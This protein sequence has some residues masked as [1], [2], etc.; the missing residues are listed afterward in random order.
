MPLEKVGSDPRG[1]RQGIAQPGGEQVVGTPHRN[2]SPH[3][4]DYSLSHRLPYIHTSYLH[5]LEDR[6]GVL[7]DLG[8]NIDALVQLIGQIA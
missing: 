1:K 6:L 5:S 4:R 3:L 2:T 7:R 8:L